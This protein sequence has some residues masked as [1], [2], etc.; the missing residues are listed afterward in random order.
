LPENVD[1]DKISA[2][3]KDGVLKVRIPKTE[4]SKSKPIQIQIR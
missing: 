3:C 2:E 1:T 4:D